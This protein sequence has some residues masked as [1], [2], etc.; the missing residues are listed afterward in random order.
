M[1]L[2]LSGDAACDELLS[3]DGFA[4]LVGMVLDQQIPLERAFSAPRLLA[5]RLGGTLDPGQLAALDP[6]E[7]V[8]AFSAKPAL[9]RFPAS[10]AERVC[11]LAAV[12]VGQYHGDA[13]SIWREAVDGTQLLAR[14][15][16]LPGF[17]RQKARIF[18]ALLG[19]QLGTAPPGWRRSCEPFGEPGS[20]LSIADIVSEETRAAVRAHKAELKAAAKAATSPHA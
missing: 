19:K 4:L 10:M 2:H 15:E 12:V 3:T 13:A 17:G 8:A 18:V 20:L 11:Q 5:E 6:S 9:H 16:A 14:I 1:G 7:L